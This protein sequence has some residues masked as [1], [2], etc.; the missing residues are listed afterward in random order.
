MTD[1]CAAPSFYHPDIFDEMM[2]FAYRRFGNFYIRWFEDE[3]SG[4]LMNILPV[5]INVA[6]FSPSKSQQK[7]L[8]KNTECFEIRCEKTVLNEE[9]DEIFFL[10]REKFTDNQPPSLDYYVG[11]EARKRMPV[12]VE[13]LTFRVLDGAKTVAAS[14]LDVGAKAASALYGMNLPEYNQYSLG[15][16]TILTEINYCKTNGIDYYYLGYVHEGNSFYDYKKKFAGTEYFDKNS[17]IWEKYTFSASMD[18][19]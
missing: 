14:F 12:I 1:F 8:R 10:H 5:R 11:E 19:C 9:L 16:F 2:F 4:K 3:T 7:I 17:G 13:N 6:E 15:I 18:K